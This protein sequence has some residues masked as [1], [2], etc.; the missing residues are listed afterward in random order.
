MTPIKYHPDIFAMIL[1]FLPSS[2]STFEWL[3]RK[4]LFV[5]IAVISNFLRFC[6]NLQPIRAVAHN[7][8]ATIPSDNLY[9]WWLRYD[10]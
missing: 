1:I 7:L 8:W 10:T 9:I 2:G 6:S 5:S 3:L 4:T